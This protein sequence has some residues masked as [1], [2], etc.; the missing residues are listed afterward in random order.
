[1]SPDP[2]R[3]PLNPATALLNDAQ[4][5]SIRS[6]LQEVADN[7]PSGT[8]LERKRD[9]ERL[10]DLTVSMRYHEADR[11]SRGV[12]VLWTYIC[13]DLLVTASVDIYGN[14]LPAAVR[15]LS[16]PLIPDGTDLVAD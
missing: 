5:A 9:I 7:W 4:M 12:D 3:N 11:P 10:T 14:G 8:S 15:R 13:D 2:A 1:M 16:E 6:A